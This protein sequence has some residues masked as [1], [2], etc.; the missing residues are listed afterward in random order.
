MK[1]DTLKLIALAAFVAG[2][3]SP[4]AACADCIA[5]SAET[6]LLTLES[7]TVDGVAIDEFSDYRGFAT[8][9]EAGYSHTAFR[10][11][12]TEGQNTWSDA[13]R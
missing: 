4:K 2:T 6:I 9:L 13:Y 5:H 8:T 7:V 3:S 12:A 11:V 1:I 10:F